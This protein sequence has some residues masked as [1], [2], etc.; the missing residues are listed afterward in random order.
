ML[1]ACHMP[2][3]KSKC[4]CQMPATPNANAKC[5]KWQAPLCGADLAKPT[6]F[7][8]RRTASRQA[9][10]LA[11]Y[12]CRGAQADAELGLEA[13]AAFGYRLCGQ[14]DAA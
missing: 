2:N 8:T 7:W 9:R 13:G 10:D 3:A 14:S 4:K 5:H 6:D 1:N 12:I 11:H